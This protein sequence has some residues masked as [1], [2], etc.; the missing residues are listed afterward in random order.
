MLSL[1]LTVFRGPRNFEPSRGICFFPQN[2]SA[3]FMFFS[4]NLTFFIR[5]LV[6]NNNTVDAEARFS[7]CIYFY[8][9]LEGCCK[10]RSATVSPRAQNTLA[11]A[12]RVSTSVV[13]DYFIDCV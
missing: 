2:F 10:A 6:L 1:G 7:K 9:Y 5:T 3:K 4:W 11:P 13:S 8:V 12:L